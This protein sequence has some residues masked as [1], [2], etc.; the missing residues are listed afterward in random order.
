MRSRRPQSDSPRLK[1]YSPGFTAASCEAE[2][3]EDWTVK[4]DE[5]DSVL[6]LVMAERG[7]WGLASLV[8]KEEMK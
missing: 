7:E 4:A 1:G 2:R 8:S 6:G 5:E 3:L